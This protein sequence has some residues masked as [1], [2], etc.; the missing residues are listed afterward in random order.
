MRQVA[1]SLL[2]DDI[3]YHA[4][5]VAR[6]KIFHPT[7]LRLHVPGDVLTL[8]QAKLMFDLGMKSLYLLEPGEGERVARK[9]LGVER[10]SARDLAPGDELREDVRRPDGEL[11]APEGSRLV[12]SILERVHE[13]SSG[14]V[15][16]R[17]R[18]MEEELRQADSYLAYYPSRVTRLPRPDTRVT[19]V[20][21]VS[22]VRV[23]PLFVPRARIFIA[24]PDELLRSILVNEMDVTGH[25]V[26]EFPDPSRAF[27]EAEQSPPDLVVLDTVDAAGFCTRL[28]EGTA[29]RK[30]V[31]LVYVEAERPSE[32]YRALQSGAN[33]VLARPPRPDLLLD[34]IRSCMEIWRRRVQVVPAV[35][36]ERR[37]ARR[38][39]VRLECRAEDPTSPRPLALSNAEVREAGPGGLKVEYNIPV[40][41]RPYAYTPHGVHPRHPLWDFAQKNPLGRDVKVELRAGGLPPVE[42]WARVIHVEPAGEFEIAGLGFARPAGP[43]A[44]FLAGLAPER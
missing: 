37:A 16:V 28:R 11:L 41:T 15:L 42:E 2:R 39:A 20:T 5:L 22:S 29:H 13:E 30:V 27:Q 7:G 44:D 43:M 36:G 1:V 4:A 40:G 17:R 12:P 18:N 3:H 35:W 38:T 26:I 32:E 19:R 24:V 6:T 33:M 14:M 8:A 25:E 23:R 9:S 10:V 34:A 31:V 21:R